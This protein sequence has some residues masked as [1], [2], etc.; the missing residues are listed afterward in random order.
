MLTSLA[1]ERVCQQCPGKRDG[2]NGD[3]GDDGDDVLV[4]VG[5]LGR[6]RLVL[7]ARGPPKQTLAP[8]RAVVLPNSPNYSPSG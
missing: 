8:L 4:L 2:D 5:L 1:S 6:G 7:W 3:D